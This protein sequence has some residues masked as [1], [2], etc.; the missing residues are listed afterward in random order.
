M[1][2]GLRTPLLRPR[3]PWRRDILARWGLRTAASRP[4][5]RFVTG[6]LAFLFMS[7]IAIGLAVQA[8]A[9]G[10]RTDSTGC[11]TQR[12]TGERHCHGGKEAEDSPSYS[13]EPATPTGETWQGIAIAPEKRCSPYNRKDYSYSQ[14]I[15][16]RIISRL[17][18]I[19]SPYTGRKFASKKETDIEHI[20][21]T[22]EAHD[23]GGCAWPA[24]RRKAFARD[25]DNLTLASPELNRHQ[26][27]GKDFAEWR[28][29]QNQCWMARTVISVK[30]KH[31]LSIDPREQ[32]A[33]AQVLAG[34]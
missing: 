10:G 23:S 30:R 14:S 15:E 18:G 17:G 2:I 19:Y 32:K 28:P 34:C 3:L 33:L 21:A 12:S 25:L 6:I 4:G 8:Q 29:P 31:G 27:S 9:H 1:R 16:N 20:V 24:S 13:G 26:K 22:S 5:R 7:L 11:H